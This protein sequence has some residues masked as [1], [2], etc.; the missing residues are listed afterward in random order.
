MIDT[1]QTEMA[2]L[3]GLMVST[4]DTTETLKALQFEPDWMHDKRTRETYVLMMEMW[5]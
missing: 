5:M 4:S 2:I 1:L 3:G